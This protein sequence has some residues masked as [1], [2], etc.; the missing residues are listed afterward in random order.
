M[1]SSRNPDKSRSAHMSQ[2]S[3]QGR[4]RG[5]Q[6]RGRGR[7]SQG[8][9]RGRDNQRSSRPRQVR[10]ERPPRQRRP[11]ESHNEKPIVPLNTLLGMFEDTIKTSDMNAL[12]HV[13]FEIR[14]GSALYQIHKRHYENVFKKL[15]E[16][17]YV[18]QGN[19][20]YMLR[21]M[22]ENI[23]DVRCE[24]ESLNDIQKY[25]RSNMIDEVEHKF[26]SKTTPTNLEDLY[27]NSDMNFRVSIKNE[28]QVNENDNRLTSI[29]GEVD[30]S[31]SKF[32]YIKRTSLVND[33]YPNVRIDMSMV[34]KH[35]KGSTIFQ[36]FV[37][38]KVKEYYYEIEIE[39]INI[40]K[41]LLT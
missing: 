8:R 39:L 1:K 15:I 11:M 12:K 30:S 32:R 24:I 40:K 21:L 36:E 17:S 9:G 31:V 34:Q 27:Y 25:C 26:I 33:K 14:F 3:S 13:E 38:K 6:G 23:S 2:R 4:G 35:H 19:D 16:T 20:N 10:I 22:F 28:E 29:M 41:I 37:S 7:G 5:S 18:K